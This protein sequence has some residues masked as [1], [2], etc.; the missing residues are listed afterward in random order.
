MKVCFPVIRDEGLD[1][2]LFGHFSSAPG[3]LVVDTGTRA[4][5]PLSNCDPMNP[6]LGCNP[7]LALAGAQLDA[8]VAEGIG[9]ATVQVMNNLGFKV[10]EAR[11]TKVAENLAGLEKGGLPERIPMD[12]RLASPCGGSGHAC[13]HH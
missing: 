8:I 3:F 11:S 12:P 5:I 4:C 6:E 10:L 1:S 2:R 9:D 13:Q 7:F